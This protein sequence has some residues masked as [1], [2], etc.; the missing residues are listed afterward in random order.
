[1]L[2]RLFP[3]TLLAATLASPAFATSSGN[4]IVNGNGET[5]L[6]AKEWDQAT[7]VPG[8]TTTQGNPVVQCYTVASIGTPNS[9]LQGN[10]FLADGPYGDS[11]MNQ[12]VSVASAASAIDAGGVTYS[13][14]GWLGGY[15]TY[16]GQATVT[17]TF[18]NASGAS[19]G[20]ASIGPVTAW[21]RGYG[22]KLLARSG[23]GNVPAGTR[24]IKTQVVFNSTNGNM[25]VGYVDNLSLTLSTP[26]TAPVLAAPV[27][28]VPAFDHVF[29][30]VLENTDY[31]EVI[32]SS[33]APYM[34]SLFSK[35]TLLTNYTGVYHPSDENYLALAGGDT[36]TAG[37][38]Y[39]PNINSTGR[40]IGDVLEGAGK[41]WKSYEQGMGTPCNMTNSADSHFH[42]D[43]AP[44]ANYTNISGNLGRCQ[45]HLVDITQL[46]ADLQSTATT[47]A[48]SWIAAD[49]WY[50]GE[51]A[52]YSN[53]SINTSL[54]AQD[55][56]LS[57]Y[58]PVLFNS[59][60]WKNQR[61]LL[62]VTF[63]ESSTGSWV[64]GTYNSVVTVAIGSQGL[65]KTGFQSGLR[66]NHYSTLRTMEAALGVGSVTANDQYAAPMN[67]VFTGN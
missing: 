61:S 20:S 8:W 12:T 40:H 45:A 48:L 47:P 59:P 14:S 60:A 53:M 63:D 43:D 57:Q 9:S 5:G 27:S 62:L 39:Y 23:S 64:S 31:S 19:I 21:D 17:S 55:Q 41:S 10:A 29:L 37:A 7:S 26:V 54:T 65:V 49:N 22:T 52:Y 4:L 36:V 56:F 24:S 51:D 30:I 11:A 66:Y 32:G 13:L 3:L 1:M 34:N 58:L 25:N 15:T 18:L 46:N 50:N 67:D 38:T 44:F 35:G 16:G 6:C 33:Y 2:K 42:A 28:K